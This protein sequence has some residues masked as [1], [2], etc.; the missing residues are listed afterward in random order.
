MSTGF[1]TAFSEIT[2]VLFTT[3]APSGAVAY[4]LMSFPI[5]RG[6]LSDDAHRRIDKALCIS[7]IVSLVGLVASATHLGNPANALYVFM[8]VGRSP[9]SNE[10]FSA[11]IFLAFSG[12]YWLYSFAVKPRRLLQRLLAVGACVSAIACIT[13]IA[14]AYSADTIVTWDTPFSPLSLWT[15]AL[16]GGPVL[17]IVGLRAARWKSRGNRFGRLMLMLAVV[18]L[19]ACLVVYALQGAI[20]LPAENAVASAGDLVPHYALLVCVFAV[21]AAAGIAVDALSLFRPSVSREGKASPDEMTISVVR[22]SV[23]ALFVLA[24]IFVM[25]FSFYMMH[26][27]VGI[28]F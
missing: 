11:V 10:V 12:V 8:G 26:M 19:A 9:L 22:A 21:F 23:A 17:A 15:N 2:L 24:G 3:L 7:L 16:L 13:A 5:I 4:A 20:V 1:A 6:R 27:T 14:F 25:R 28:S 18:A